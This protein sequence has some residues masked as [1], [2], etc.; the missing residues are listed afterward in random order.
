LGWISPAGLDATIECFVRFVFH[1][2]MRP[3]RAG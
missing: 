2:S 3:N 1:F